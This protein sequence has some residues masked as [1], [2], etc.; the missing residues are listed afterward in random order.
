VAQARLLESTL[1]FDDLTVE[2]IADNKH[3]PPR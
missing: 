2:M 1:L 3:L